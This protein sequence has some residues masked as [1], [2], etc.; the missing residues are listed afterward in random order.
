MSLASVSAQQTALAAAEAAAA[1]GPATTQVSTQ[2]TGGTAATDGTTGQ[3]ALNALS[4]NFQSFLGMLMT[5]LQNQ[6]PTSP[7]DSN[8]FTQELVAFSGVEQQINTNNS[9]TQLIQL[10]QSGELMQAAAMTGKQVDVTS[11]QMPLQNGSGSVQF[12]LNA[13]EPVAIAIAN[14]SGQVVKT[15]MIDGQ[16][17]ANSWTWNGISDTGAQMPDGAYDVSVYGAGASG[18][19]APVP[20][21]VGG[22]VTGTQNT[23]GNGMQLQ[24]GP[25]QVGFGAVQSMTN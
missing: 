11:D 5:Q 3:A 18:T 20:F 1:Q 2:S 4:G 7:L 14:A 17:G 22:T 24:L 12:S 15:A 13:A 25:V 9:L 23:S 10:T 16:A 19:T 8:Q 21:T 6:D